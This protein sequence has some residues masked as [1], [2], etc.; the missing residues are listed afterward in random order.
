MSCYKKYT[1][2]YPINSGVK[3]LYEFIS[4]PEAFEQWFSEKVTVVNGIITFKWYD[5]E[6]KARIIGKKENEWVRYQW[7]NE[8]EHP[9]H[10]LEFRINIEP[11]TN[12]LALIITDFCKP[13]EEE[14]QKELW[15]MSINNLIKKIGGNPVG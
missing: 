11:V 9:L 12:D 2:E 1:I 14:E 4:T 5:S 15:D 3:I 10:Y 13:E 8:H 7:L 6:L